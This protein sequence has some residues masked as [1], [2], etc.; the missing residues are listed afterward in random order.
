[1]GECVRQSVSQYPCPEPVARAL[2]QVDTIE[3]VDS[4]MDIHPI[5]AQAPAG[6]TNINLSINQRTA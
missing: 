4:S 6:P 1:M 5:P 2:S 3:W